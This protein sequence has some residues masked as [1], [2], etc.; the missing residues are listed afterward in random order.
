MNTRSAMLQPK[1]N[2]KL[3][4]SV[5]SQQNFTKTS[6]KHECKKYCGTIK[7]ENWMIITGQCTT[8]PA[9]NFRIDG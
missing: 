3:S 8:Q 2:K 9:E 7:T 5:G 6:E 4:F 1:L